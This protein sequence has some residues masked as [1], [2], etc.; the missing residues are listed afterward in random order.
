MG[1]LGS[2]P[3][4]QN[5][6]L[7]GFRPLGQVAN[8]GKL[9]PVSRKMIEPGDQDN[10]PQG[11][12]LSRVLKLKSLVQRHEDIEMRRRFHHQPPVG[13]GL[14]AHFRNGLYRVAGKKPGGA[15]GSHTRQ[16]GC[17][18]VHLLTGEFQKVLG[19]SPLQ[20]RHGLQELV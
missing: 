17:A 14:P 18:F 3:D 5:T 4:R 8:L 13:E 12:P 15:A 11:V 6:D 20:R 2:S 16:G 7:S 10:D 1:R 19:L 9:W